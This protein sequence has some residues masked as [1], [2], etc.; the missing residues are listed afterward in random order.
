MNEKLG[1]IEKLDVRSVWPNEAT[2]FTPW[3]AKE[4][5]IQ[6][7]SKAIGIELE[8]E[9]MEVAVGPYSADILARDSATG[10]FVVIENQL[11]KT[12][13]DHLGKLLTYSAVLDADTI[14]WI[15]KEFTDEHKKSLDWLNDKSSDDVAFFGVR[16]ELWKIDNS[17]PAF[18]FNIVCRP[19]EINRSTA[20]GLSGKELSETKKI[21]LEFWTAF[22]DAL[23]ETKQVSSLQKPRP[24]YWHNVSLGRTGIHLSNIANTSDNRI[25][26]RVYMVN[27][28]NSSAALAQLSEQKTEIEKEIGEK[29]IWNPNTD[30]LDKVIVLHHKADL[31]KKDKW[32][33]YIKW[34][35]EKTILFRK[36]FGPR[37]TELNLNSESQ[38]DEPSE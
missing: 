14:I 30:A 35:V 19:T 11:E 32:P 17:K 8:V 12:N 36:V 25:G 20:I 15:A 4:E 6:H 34:L 7:L 3:L 33:D 26:V 23:S 24:Q 5:N 31:K 28:Y 29:L 37:I 21:Q 16:L 1:T 38:Q 13:H 22:R 27:R 18:Q 9:N 10:R 2:D